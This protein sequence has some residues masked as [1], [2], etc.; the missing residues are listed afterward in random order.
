MINTTLI[1]DLPLSNV[2]NLAE[3]Q[4]K[5]A[6]RCGR[7]AKNAADPRRQAAFEYERDVHINK[8]LDVL[9]AAAYPRLTTQALVRA[10]GRSKA[11]VLKIE[12]PIINLA[13]QNG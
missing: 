1:R 8:M 9:E 13:L 11:L 6:L 3:W 12:R 10:I 4:A 2:A 5:Q 7:A